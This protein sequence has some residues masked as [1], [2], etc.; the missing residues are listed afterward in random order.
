MDFSSSVI[1]LFYKMKQALKM[2][3]YTI[4]LLYQEK[5]NTISQISNMGKSFKRWAF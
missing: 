1:G 5:D 2:N 4:V 3:K